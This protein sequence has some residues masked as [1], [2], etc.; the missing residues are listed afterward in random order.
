MI[1]SADIAASQGDAG[2]TDGPIC[3]RTYTSCS[4]NVTVDS[5][6]GMNCSELV[7]VE[8]WSLALQVCNSLQD[9]FNIISSSDIN[10][11][12]CIEVYI[13]AGDYVLTGPIEITTNVIIRGEYNGRSSFHVEEGEAI[14]D[15]C[16][17]LSTTEPPPPTMTSSPPTMTSSSPLSGMPRKRQQ[18]S[19]EVCG[20]IPYADDFDV[21]VTV[22]GDVSDSQIP[23]YVL[24]FL[25]S[26]QV[27]MSGILF[28]NSTGIFAF[29]NVSFVSLKNCSFR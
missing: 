10:I 23:Y 1:T 19:S 3:N 12:D 20:D 8:G 6:L 2:C 15:I 5:Q 4:V 28:T 18:Q 22:A 25:N 21:R 24:S 7:S 9:V 11:T 17:G 29:E 16:S 26:D 27:E 14:S 13:R